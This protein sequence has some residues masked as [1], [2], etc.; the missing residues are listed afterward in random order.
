MAIDNQKTMN[1]KA[2]EKLTQNSKEATHD[3]SMRG[4]L[5]PI[6]VKELVLDF[7]NPPLPALDEKV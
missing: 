6:S 1:M 3:A 5:H 2:G 4:N 7:Q